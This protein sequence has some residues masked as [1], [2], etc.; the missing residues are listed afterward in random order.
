MIPIITAFAGR[1]TVADSMMADVFRQTRRADAPA[2][3][4]IRAYRQR[5]CARPAFARAYDDQVGHFVEADR[6]RSG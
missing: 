2:Y 5:V 3:P 1:F 6:V 4:N